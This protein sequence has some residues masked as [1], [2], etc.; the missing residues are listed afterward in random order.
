MKILAIG[1][2]HGEFPYKLEQRLRKENFDV[3][4]GVGD[5]CGIDE[6]WPYIRYIFRATKNNEKVISAEKFFGKK[7]YNELL[8]KD[9]YSMK[10]V[11]KKLNSFGKLVLFV[12]GN[13]DDGWYNYPFAKKT[14]INYKLRIKKKNKRFLKSLNN[15]IDLNYKNKKWKNFNLIGFGGYMDIEAFFKGDFIRKRPDLLRARQSRM[16]EGR[17]YLFNL[18]TKIDKRLDTLLILHYPPKRVF[19]IIRDKKSTLNGKSAG[20]RFFTEAIKKYKPFLVLCGHMHEYQGIKRLYGVPVVNPGDAGKGKAAIIEL[21]GGKI[22]KIK[23]I[24]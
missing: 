18:F 6:F 12:M 20:V 22:K 5:Y 4:V 19:D 8:K 10:K 7:R 9:E 11:L 21:D 2:F 14:T 1:D 24:R 3:I 15:F 16:K 13:G 17:I 23:F